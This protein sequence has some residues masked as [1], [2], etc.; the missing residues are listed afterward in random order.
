[1]DQ[2]VR[3]RGKPDGVTLLALYAVLLF[4]IPSR[5]TVGPLGGAGSP[6]LVLGTG[7]AFLWI[8]AMVHREPIPATGPQ[9]VRVAMG[10]LLT[11]FLIS[12]VAAMVRPIAA[13]ERAAAD[14][15]LVTLVAWSG[16]LFFAHDM[17]PSVE[18]FLDLCRHLTTGG[19]AL[20]G[21]G[22][23]QF[24]TG[25]QWVDRI[26]VPGL[27]ENSSFAAITMREG[28][29]RP[30]GTA[31]HPIEFGAVLTM[32]LPLALALALSDT[33]RSAVRRWA[34]PVLIIT[35]ITLSVSRS[36]ILGAVVGVIVFASTLSA[37]T[38]RTLLAASVAFVVMVFLTVPGMLGTMLG[39][40]TNSGNDSSV[41]SRTGSY[42]VAGDF[43]GNAPVFGRGFG[44]FLPSYRIFD[45]Q[46]LLSFV[47][48]GIVGVL[49]MLGLFATAIFAGRRTRVEATDPTLSL[50][51]QG[52]AAAACVGGT[53]L[54]IYD[55]FSFPMGTGTLFVLLGMAGC[56]Y[57]LVRLERGQVGAA[58]VA[59]SAGGTHD[60]GSGRYPTEEVSP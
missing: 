32:L 39:L 6:A 59:S 41:E 48:V 40:F 53:G 1:V 46:F 49:C 33:G 60:A 10:V 34:P 29:H 35:A 7:C 22:I 3:A 44:T 12:Y 28:F 43:I 54:A 26:Q 15:G 42:G 4:A 2:E 19:A 47:D 5:L 56:A 51:G 27:S 38:I 14:L 45:N 9:P 30:T 20:A 50:V 37:R 13:D 16:V 25:Q 21:V 57:R 23:V 52:L 58:P 18:R 11:A 8:F 36:A 24:V 55:G 17:I 31:L